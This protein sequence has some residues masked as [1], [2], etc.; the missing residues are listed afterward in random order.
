MPES[1]I[2]PRARAA[3]VVAVIVGLPL[4]FAVIGLFVAGPFA[5]SSRPAIPSDCAA[6]FVDEAPPVSSQGR[7]FAEVA[8]V[9]VYDCRDR[10][11]VAVDGVG[12]A[13]EAFTTGEGGGVIA[14]I[15][16]VDE[17]GELAGQRVV[18]RDGG[19]VTVRSLNLDGDL[20]EVSADEVGFEGTA[21]V[22]EFVRGRGERRLVAVEVGLTE[23][24]GG[25]T[26][27]D[28][29]TVDVE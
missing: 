29:L 17:T 16:L 15:G 13:A 20:V 4:A 10:F 25:G 26:V 21:V 18:E 9:R 14:S 8:R 19:S 2:S 27:H 5:P 1:R 28:S 24:V 11:V 7:R 6:P 23:T 3:A 22:V 12:G